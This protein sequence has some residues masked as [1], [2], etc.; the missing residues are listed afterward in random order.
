MT[1]QIG[2]RILSFAIAHG[3]DV[4][5]GCLLRIRDWM[6]PAPDRMGTRVDLLDELY[7]RGG[8]VRI[9]RHTR[10][11]HD[12]RAGYD[13]CNLVG[14]HRPEVRRFSNPARQ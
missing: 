4:G 11:R 7:E 8:Q 13:M 14:L 2:N 9:T 6:N 10:E 3:I 5:L 12:V 1:M